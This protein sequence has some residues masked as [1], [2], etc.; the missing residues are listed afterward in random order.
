MHAIEKRR[1]AAGQSGFTLI[2]LLV[3]I[4][5]LGILAAVVV[6]AVGNATT[7]AQSKACAIELREMQT[8]AEAYKGTSDTGDYPADISDMTDGGDSAFLQDTPQNHDYTY[9]GVGDADITPNANGKCSD[10]AHLGA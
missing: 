9:N 5:I 6:F 4:A 7:S 2:E 10:S 1:E 3:V 8:A